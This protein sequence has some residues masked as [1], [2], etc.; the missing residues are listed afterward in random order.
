MFKKKEKNEPLGLSSTIIFFGGDNLRSC[1][2][3]YIRN[4]DIFMLMWNSSTATI[5]SNSVYITVS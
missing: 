3:K 4:Y 1:M 5:L 2:W